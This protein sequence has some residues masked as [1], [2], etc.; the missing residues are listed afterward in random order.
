MYLMFKFHFICLLHLYF[1]PG[2]HC[3]NY[4]QPVLKKKNNSVSV[5][6]AIFHWLN[7]KFYTCINIF[8]GVTIARAKKTSI[9]MMLL[10][11]FVQFM[12]QIGLN[13]CS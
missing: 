11:N 4:S 1:G 3:S 13:V 7:Q 10:L 5:C 9:C 6:N 2:D 12:K 8:D